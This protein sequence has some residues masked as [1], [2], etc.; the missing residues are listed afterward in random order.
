MY[1]EYKINNLATLKVSK[2]NNV[3]IIK[4][5]V[6]EIKRDSQSQTKGVVIEV[7]TTCSASPPSP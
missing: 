4:S 5:R 6:G 2:Y 1:C 3:R 7:Q